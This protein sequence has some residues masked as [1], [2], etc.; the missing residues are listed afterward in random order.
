MTDIKVEHAAA[1]NESMDHGKKHGS[2]YGRFLAMIATSTIIMLGLMYL[3]SYQL[4]HV[5]FSETRTYMALYM[6]GMMSLVMLAFMWGMYKDKAKN[7]MIVAG[8]VLLFAI[9]LFLV[10]SQVTVQD[11]AWMKAM[12]PHH[13]I[14]IL[15]SERAEIDDV[16]VR[17][18]ADEIIEAQRRE[19]AE[20]EWLIQDIKENGKATTD[21]DA[22]ARPV[23]DFSGD[24]GR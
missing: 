16:R 24:D 23:P 2:S 21:A 9:A 10:R 13:S 11:R 14:A 20:M 8:S 12:I 18:L 22:D 1:D 7:W 4:S 3:N 6:G 19:I 17:E 15:T 5:R